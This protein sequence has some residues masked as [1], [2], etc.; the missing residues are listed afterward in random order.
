MTVKKNITVALGCYIFVGIAFA[1]ALAAGIALKAHG[2]TGD[3]YNYWKGLAYA[4]WASIPMVLAL[5]LKELMECAVSSNGES[6]FK[7]WE[8]Y[9][10]P[11]DKIELDSCGISRR[12]IGY[13][14]KTDYRWF[15]SWEELTL[16]T[17][18]WNDWGGF[19]FCCP[20][21]QPEVEGKGK[22]VFFNVNFFLANRK[23][24]MEFAV[25][26]LP[27]E[28][29]SDGALL[30]LKKMGIFARRQTKTI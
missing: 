20:Y 29:I 13:A 15:K 16:S 14:G 11:K 17:G 18:K 10:S 19:V 21:E 6:L 24:L 8:E 26:K 5:M 12:G 3:E 30:K 25:S 22:W 4:W 9:I 27:V 7:F 28:N 1:M 2:E 23:Q